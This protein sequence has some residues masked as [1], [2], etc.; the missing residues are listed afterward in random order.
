MSYRA[1]ALAT[2][3]ATIL[4]ACS[5]STEVVAPARRTS[6]LAVLGATSRVVYTM[7][8]AAHANEIVV[9]GFEGSTVSEVARVATGGR[10]SGLSLSSDGSVVLTADARWLLATNAGSNQVSVF[11]VNRSGI[12]LTDVV[13]S[14]GSKPVSIAVHGDLVYV[15]NAGVPNDVSGFQLSAGGKLSPLRGAI[16]NLSDPDAKPT[17]IEFT[18]DG[19]TLVVIERNTARLTTFA[20][21]AS[22]LIAPP[23]SQTTGYPRPFGSLFAPDGQ[24]VV[25]VESDEKSGGGLASFVFGRQGTAAR[26]DSVPPSDSIPSSC[27]LELTTS[28]ELG[29]GPSADGFIFATS[30]AVG[31][32]S[33]FRYGSQGKVSSGTVAAGTGNGSKPT[34]IV[35]KGGVLSVLTPGAGSVHYFE[36]GADGTLVGLAV[37]SGLPASASGLAAR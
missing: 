32:V 2:A 22:G 27:W 36:I 8:N 35:S 18:P 33:M 5:D 9:H 1:L 3:S 37:V 34:D 29:L 17:D 14:G 26:A 6:S 31:I 10:G 24:L 4:A 25:T 20:V 30:P 12:S 16:R 11:R 15:L 28:G 13:P 23:K 21:Q 7:T 19:K